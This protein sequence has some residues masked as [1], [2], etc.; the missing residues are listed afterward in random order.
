MK[1]VLVGGGAHRYL[2]VARSIL[3]EGSLMENGE[4]NILDLDTERAEV[5]GRMIE[6]SPEYPGSGCKVVWDSSLEGALEGADV[7]IVVLMAGDRKT[8]EKSRTLCG[9]YGFIGSDQLSPS[10]AFLGLKGGKIIM[11]I[12][13][14]MEELCPNALLLDFAN[15][16]AVLSA[17]VNN[18][19]KIRCLGVCAGY[20]NHIW[21]L[22]RIL[23]EDS[24]KDKYD[25]KCAG[26][27]HMSFILRD[28]QYITGENLYDVIDRRL[29]EG[30]WQ[31]P[32]L[33]PRWNEFA[34]KNLTKSVN[35][36][37]R[38]YKKYGWLVFSSEGDGL[39]HLEIETVYRDAAANIAKVSDNE[40]DDDLNKMLEGRTK[41]NAAFKSF[42][43][44]D[45]PE[46]WSK[47]SP[48]TTNLLR[49]D[50][51]IMTKCIKA[52][53]GV[54]DMKIATSYLNNGAVKGFSDRTVLEYS[55]I[56]GKNVI[57]AVPDLEVPPVFY[58]LVAGLASHQ[59]LLGDAIATEDP[60]ILFEALYSYP[61]QQDTENS[62]N[63]FKE[64]IKLSE[65]E[66]PASFQKTID[67]FNN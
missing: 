3:A 62:K 6:K 44:N 33:L 29:N 2:G 22:N 13:R 43:E 5:M 30:E 38:L 50:D 19:T 21:D 53:G 8:Y 41:G 46:I 57:T 15:P 20:T 16:V 23:G 67:Y 64:L 12:A 10:G 40:I 28:S 55:Q 34:I 47:E 42:L 1:I 61:V 27:N 45:D 18:H 65:K 31:L 58:G 17:A 52:I 35:T 54:G 4:I 9:K 26:V 63:L 66:L 11:G 24:P 59:T 56:L 51:N 37:M 25:I 32:E 60:K 39:A 49:A 48:E 7:V 36:L 14:K